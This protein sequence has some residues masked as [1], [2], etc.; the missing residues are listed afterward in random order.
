MEL[1]CV[2]Q[3]ENNFSTS[4]KR[5]SKY[6]QVAHL[7][8]TFSSFQD[9]LGKKKDRRFLKRP[10]VKR[11]CLR[12]FQESETGSSG[13]TWIWM[14]RFVKI[15]ST[16]WNFPSM[17]FRLHGKLDIF[18]HGPV[19]VKSFWLKTWCKSSS[20]LFLRISRYVKI[21]RTFCSFCTIRI[22]MHGSRPMVILNSPPEAY[23]CPLSPLCKN[24]R[25]QF[26]RIMSLKPRSVIINLAFLACQDSDA[27]EK[28]DDIFE[29]LN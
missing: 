14:S 29:K 2:F 12:P 9:S 15:I 11:C 26:W 24:S 1:Q 22:L 20:Q 13:E 16:L 5:C 3:S 18:C 28:M 6:D 27:K 4:K 19:Q 25:W 23:S 17:R 21:F 8:L 10:A 7:R